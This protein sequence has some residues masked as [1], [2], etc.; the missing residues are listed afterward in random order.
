M[1]GAPAALREV[2]GDGGMQAV[3]T[4]AATRNEGENIR[5]IIHELMWELKIL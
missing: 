3:E 4:S 5:E 2:R 1:E